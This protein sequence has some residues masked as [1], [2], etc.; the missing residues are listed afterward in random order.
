MDDTNEARTQQTPRAVIDAIPVEVTVEL[1][2]SAAT[3][4]EIAAWRPGEVI[5]FPSPLG[6]PVVVRGGGRAVARGELVD[7]EG[8]VG[9]RVTEVL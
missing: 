8:N 5:E 7:V 9:V 3:V 1:A 6:A 2:R 4:A